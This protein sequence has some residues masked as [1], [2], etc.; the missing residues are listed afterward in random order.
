M[1]AP[2]TV[3][4]GRPK[5]EEMAEVEVV[6][7]EVQLA[8][9]VFRAISLS[10]QITQQGAEPANLI[11][12]YLVQNYFRQGY[13]IYSIQHLRTEMSEGVPFAEQMLYVLVKYAE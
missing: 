7:E 3:K 4:R 10:S 13:E 6:S 9:S 1:D 5:K 12:D 2:A 11:E 8:S